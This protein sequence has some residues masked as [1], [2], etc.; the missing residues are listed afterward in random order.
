MRNQDH[1]IQ[2]PYV[3]MLNEDPHLTKNW[4]LDNDHTSGVTKLE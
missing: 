2:D 4:D 1:G 3:H